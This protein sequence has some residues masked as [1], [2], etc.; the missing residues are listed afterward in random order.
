[1]I[2][3]LDTASDAPLYVQLCNQIILGIGSGAL[4][5]GERLPTVRQLAQ[6]ACVNVM[7]VSKAYQILKREGYI[8]IDRRHG[9]RVS[10]AAAHSGE[11][12][13]RTEQQLALLAVESALHGLLKEDFLSLCERAYG[14]LRIRRG[15]AMV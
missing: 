2:V 10:L 8:E 1:M 13:E 14:G 7:T 11:F 9:A 12:R 3:M 15:E 6:D 5:L 4:A